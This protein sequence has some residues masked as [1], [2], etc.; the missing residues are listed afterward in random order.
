MSKFAEWIARKHGDKKPNFKKPVNRKKEKSVQ[1]R[2]EERNR[3]IRGVTFKELA[4]GA[5]PE[6][7]K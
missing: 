7:K 4:G 2:A 3:R 1:E 6:R 5:K